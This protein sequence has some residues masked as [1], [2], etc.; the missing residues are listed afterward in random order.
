MIM[1][2]VS[3]VDGIRV[4]DDTKHYLFWLRNTTGFFGY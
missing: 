4:V 2:F 1:F 3:G